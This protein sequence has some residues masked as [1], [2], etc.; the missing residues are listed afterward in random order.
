VR[1]GSFCRPQ[2]A[3]LLEFARLIEDPEL[4]AV[5]EQKGK[6]CAECKDCP[7][8]D[9]Y[10]YEDLDDVIVCCGCNLDKD[11]NDFKAPDEAAMDA[12]IQEHVKAGHHTFQYLMHPGDE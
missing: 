4:R 11:R 1:W 5:R 10:I 9:L 2:G 3:Y 7:G 8:S 12:H 6:Q